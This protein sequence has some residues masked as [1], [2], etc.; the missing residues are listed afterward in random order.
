[1]ERFVRYLLAGGVGLVAGL[2]FL[3]LSARYSTPWFLGGALLV[4]GGGGL[5]PGTGIEIE[6]TDSAQGPTHGEDSHDRT[7]SDA[8]RNTASPRNA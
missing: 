1:M 6:A 2:W 4:G 5:A 7:C 8:S 3:E